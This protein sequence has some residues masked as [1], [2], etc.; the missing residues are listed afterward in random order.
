METQEEVQA[1]LAEEGA[2]NKLINLSKKELQLVLRELGQDFGPADRKST[3][4]QLASAAI[5]TRSF[6]Q[7]MDDEEE[8][9]EE[10]VG[11]YARR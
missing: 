6:S 7:D 9:E 11:W 10:G 1:F 8:E 4:I 5:L 2:V 3:L